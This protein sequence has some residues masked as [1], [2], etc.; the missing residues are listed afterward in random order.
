[1]LELSG[2]TREFR[3]GCYHPTNGSNFDGIKRGVA[4]ASASPVDTREG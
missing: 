4:R 3:R 2:G 1:L